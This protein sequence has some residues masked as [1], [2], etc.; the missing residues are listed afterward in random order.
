MDKKELFNTLKRDPEFRKKWL[1]ERKITNLKRV[2]TR[3]EIHSI[4][5]D[6]GNMEWN[7]CMDGV[8]PTIDDFEYLISLVHFL[9]SNLEILDNYFDD[10]LLKLKEKYHG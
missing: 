2:L 8:N 5:S 9:L 3:K 6:L 7:V 4:R 1:D 10:D